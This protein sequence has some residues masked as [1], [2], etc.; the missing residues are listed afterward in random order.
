MIGAVTYLNLLMRKGGGKRKKIEDEKR[1]LLYDHQHLDKSPST[2]S[3]YSEELEHAEIYEIESM[4]Y[5]NLIIV[6]GI[7]RTQL[8]VAL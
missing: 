3:C 8:W 4:W 2:R 5:A 7:C 6:P 1:L